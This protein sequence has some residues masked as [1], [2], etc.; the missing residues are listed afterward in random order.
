[1]T[2]NY[3]VDPLDLEETCVRFAKT[4]RLLEKAESTEIW[5]QF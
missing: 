1:M 2:V 3:Q 5:L 4:K